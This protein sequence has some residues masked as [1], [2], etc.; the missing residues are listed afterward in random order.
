MGR[1]IGESMR[2]LGA[3]QT[4]APVLD[5][6]RAVEKVTG[7]TV[8]HTIAPRRAGDPPALYADSTK[9]QR[10]LGWQIKFPDIEFIVATAWKWH[11][12]HPEGF[13]KQNRKA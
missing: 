1:L 11:A 2:E 4:L 3:H 13:G 8:P 12:A 5:V 7:K 9:A 10:E 6:I